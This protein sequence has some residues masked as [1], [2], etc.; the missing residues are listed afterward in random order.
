MKNATI[1]MREARHHV[2][3][4]ATYDMIVG[5]RSSGHRI[6][7]VDPNYKAEGPNV[8]EVNSD[9]R[10]GEAMAAAL[11]SIMRSRDGGLG[12]HISYNR[13]YQAIQHGQLCMAV[14]DSIGKRAADGLGAP[15]SSDYAFIGLSQVNGRIR[16]REIPTNVWYYSDFEISHTPET[17]KGDLKRL[18]NLMAGGFDE[19]R[20]AFENHWIR[21]PTGNWQTYDAS[22]PGLLTK[23]RF[24]SECIGR[25]DGVSA[26]VHMIAKAETADALR[27]EIARFAGENGEAIADGGYIVVKPD[28]GCTRAM[29]VRILRADRHGRVSGD[30]IDE[31]ASFLFSTDRL[32]SKFAPPTQWLIELGADRDVVRFFDSGTSYDMY[33]DLVPMVVAGEVVS[34]CAKVRSVESGTPI[35]LMPGQNP[36]EIAF[37]DVESAADVAKLRS[38]YARLYG[39]PELDFA[40]DEARGADALR[41]HLRDSGI[42]DKAKAA[43]VAMHA[44]S[45]EMLEES[46]PELHGS[47]AGARRR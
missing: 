26:P 5:P 24:Y 19:M 20:T 18:R 2:L 35:G 25:V 43:A 16:Y 32:Y 14:F 36:S 15:F 31:V 21:W 38:K 10:Y 29:G 42:L 28:V 37:L 39:I 45:A 47:L 12:L 27:S 4:S 23:S 7:V 40:I 34:T 1:T 41:S 17:I 33:Y 11:R 46:L 8:H 9:G 13:S 22:V 30:D 3:P 44:R 6:T